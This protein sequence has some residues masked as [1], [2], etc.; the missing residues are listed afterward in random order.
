MR[1]KKIDIWRWVPSAD[2]CEACLELAGDHPECPG[3]PHENCKCTCVKYD[4]QINP[5]KPGRSPYQTGSRLSSEGS[6]GGMDTWE[7]FVTCMEHGGDDDD[8]EDGGSGGDDW[9]PGKTHSGSIDLPS[10]PYDEGTP[11]WGEAIERRNAMLDRYAN[12]LYESYC[13]G[14][15]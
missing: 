15:V 4:K 9:V 8:D 12:D 6:R 3:K 2:A 13:V 10:P 7:V 1:H 14:F 5:P 11:E